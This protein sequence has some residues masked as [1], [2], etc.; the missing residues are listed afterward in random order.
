M[1][2]LYHLEIPYSDNSF[3]TIVFRS[4]TSFPVFRDI[5]ADLETREGVYPTNLI[6][7]SDLPIA[8]LRIPERASSSHIT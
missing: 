1:N 3:A 2:T 8:N 6:L 4:L 5:M 7:Y